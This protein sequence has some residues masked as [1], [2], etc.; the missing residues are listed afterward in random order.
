MV[1]QY[2]VAV[3]LGGTQIRTA[4]CDLDGRILQRASQLTLAHEGPEAVLDRIADTISTVMR[5]QSPSSVK[6]IGM[7]SPGPLNPNTG[8]ILEAPNLPGWCNVPLRDLIGKRFGI[9]TYLGNDANVAALAEYT[10]GAGR[11]IRDMIYIT[12]STGVGSGIII[13]GRMLIGA[14][15]QAGEAGH[16]IV[17]P[18]GPLCGCGRHG[19]LE[20]L[21]SGPAIAR[22]VADRLRDGAES[23]MEA[24]VAGDLSRIDA[25]LVNDAA[26]SGDALAIEAFA[27][28]GHWLGAGI[29]NLLYLFNP[30]L[31]V[32]GGSV[33]KAGS[34]LFDPMWAAIRQLARPI[35]Y[36][37]LTIVPAT[38]GDDVAL[39]GSAA[40]A[41]SALPLI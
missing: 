38:L 34:L 29:V 28:A 13:D 32:L 35:Y 8:I 31:V 17:L 18:D 16:A 36:D 6:A 30:S 15:G 7:D 33:T 12:V 2:V 1:Q 10:Y 24:M 41:I 14:N 22:Y 27:R 26:Q 20:S 4:L 11:G 19:C 5:G 23:T 40:L 3:D 21:A 25:R 37:G 9:P 39:L